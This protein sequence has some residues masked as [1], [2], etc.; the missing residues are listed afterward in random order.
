MHEH[1]H[2][3][4]EAL[5]Q[6]RVRVPRGARLK[7]EVFTG[8]LSAVMAADGVDPLQLVREAVVHL[9]WRS[10]PETDSPTP[11][12]IRQQLHGIDWLRASSPDE[13]T[14]FDNKNQQVLHRLDLVV[15]SGP[16]VK[17]ADPRAHLEDLRPAPT[18]LVEVK[19]LASQSSLTKAMIRTDAQKLGLARELLRIAGSDAPD[20]ACAVVVIALEDGEPREKGKKAGRTP[21]AVRGW[22]EDLASGTDPLVPP[23]VHFF[24]VLPDGIWSPTSP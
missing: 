5:E 24:G 13:V 3:L 14:H 17:P 20:P 15:L 21:D 2:R 16:M 6:L 4:H 19:C 7:E 1:L 12:R 10:P 9:D 11:D 18:L 22:L 23:D 8:W